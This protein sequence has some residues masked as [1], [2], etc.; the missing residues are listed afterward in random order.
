MEKLTQKEE[1]L[2]HIFWSKGPMFVREIVD[3]YP[4]PKPHFNTLSTF[5]RLLENK[6]YLSHEQVGNS[7]RYYALVDEEEFSK[8]SLKDVIKHCFK[9]SYMNAVSTLVEEDK[10]SVEDLR[11]LIERV[12]KQK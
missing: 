12:E 4:D 3:T 5:V 1:E 6:G 2:M 7:Y 10:I 9:N 11:E 8:T